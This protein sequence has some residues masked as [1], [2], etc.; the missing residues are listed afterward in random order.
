ME[1]T[2]VAGPAA[3]PKCA[4]NVGGSGF[5]LGTVG[6]ETRILSPCFRIVGV[7]EVQVPFDFSPRV[8]EVCEC[9]IAE[10]GGGVGGFL[11]VLLNQEQGAECT[12]A[13]DLSFVMTPIATIASLR[14][15]MWG[16][17]AVRSS[18]RSAKPVPG[19]I[20][21]RVLQTVGHRWR[22]GRGP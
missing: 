17:S 1:A 5:P 6:I 15:S 3:V 12:D 10:Q 22:S 19:R 7:H 21:S 8:I 18:A 9:L 11:V 13:V 16:C 14:A 2:T 20:I 4:Q